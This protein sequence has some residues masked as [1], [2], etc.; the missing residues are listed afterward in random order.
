MSRI[1]RIAEMYHQ[2]DSDDTMDL[3]IAVPGY[4]ASPVATSL[5]IPVTHGYVAKTVDG[6]EALTLADGKPGQV[7]IINAVAVS[8]G[9]GTLAPTTVTGWTTVAFTDTGDQVVLLYVNDIIGWIIMS[10]FGLTEQP[11]VA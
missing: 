5:V 9:T 11:T 7:L 8:V 4:T 3:T 2:Q 10:T 1:I 6:A